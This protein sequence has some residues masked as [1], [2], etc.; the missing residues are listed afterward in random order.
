MA[1]IK[2]KMT[3][4]SVEDFLKGI[5]DAKKRQDSFA[6][7]ELMRD[8][9]NTEPRMWGPSM[10]GFGSY[11]YKYASGHEGDALVVGFSPRKQNLTLYVLSGFDGQD[12]LLKKLGKFTTGKACLYFK[13]LEDIDQAVLKE[14]VGKTVEHMKRTYPTQDI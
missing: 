4:A 2:T 1:E 11:H 12:E 7:L 10:I 8:V 13:R 14:L 5:P 6:I 9:T 3:D